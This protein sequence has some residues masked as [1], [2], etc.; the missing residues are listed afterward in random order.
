MGVLMEAIANKTLPSRD[1]VLSIA[2]LF[3][4][5]VFA[6]GVFD[7]IGPELSTKGIIFGLLAAIT[8]PCIYLQV[9]VYLLMFQFTQ[10][11]F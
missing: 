3:V 10:K 1:K 6:G 8:F 9:D 7:G 2:I 4:G 11:A 5:T